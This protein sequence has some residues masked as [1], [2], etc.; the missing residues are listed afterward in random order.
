[1]SMWWSARGGSTLFT[2]GRGG[3]LK[4]IMAVLKYNNHMLASLTATLVRIQCRGAPPG[5]VVV[6]WQTLVA[7]GPRSVV[8]TATHASHA[9]IHGSAC[10]AL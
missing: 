7:V 5:G 6:E 8:L 9:A 3:Y 2:K 4:C 10:H 1:M